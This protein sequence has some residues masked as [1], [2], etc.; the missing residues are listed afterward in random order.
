[1]R[2]G[3]DELAQDHVQWPNLAL[4]VINLRE[5]LSDS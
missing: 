2:V 1:M 4:E 3:V 5:V